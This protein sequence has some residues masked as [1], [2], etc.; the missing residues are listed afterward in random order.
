MIRI[1]SSLEYTIR[2]AIVFHV[3]E[4]EKVTVVEVEVVKLARTFRV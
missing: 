1:Y 2:V 4:Y 3:D